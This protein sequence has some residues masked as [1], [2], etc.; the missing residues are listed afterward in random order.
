MGLYQR[1]CDFSHITHFQPKQ[2]NIHTDSE[3]IKSS[4]K[5]QVFIF[6]YVRW[7][8]AQRPIAGSN[9][10]SQIHFTVL[11]VLPI[12][13]LC[14]FNRSFVLVGSQMDHKTTIIAYTNAIWPLRT[15]SDYVIEGHAVHFA[16]PNS[17]FRGLLCNKQSA[18]FLKKIQFPVKSGFGEGLTSDFLLAICQ[19]CADF[20]KNHQTPTDRFS[21]KIIRFT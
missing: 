18:D 5:R 12:P 3:H 2:M 15:G 8:V 14:Q 1:V 16:H 7:V 6:S 10:R 9:C 19:L 17:V 11:A 4:E 21:P 20:Q 13:M